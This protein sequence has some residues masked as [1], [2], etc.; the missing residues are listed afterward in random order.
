MTSPNL[1]NADLRRLP[2]THDVLNVF[3]VLAKL[4]SGHDALDPSAPSLTVCRM[5]DGRFVLVEISGGTGCVI[6]DPVTASEAMEIAYGALSGDATARDKLFSV[7][8]AFAGVM[9]SPVD[10]RTIPPLPGDVIALARLPAARGA[11]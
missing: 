7:A 6:G 11:A 10:N 1:P 5:P 9:C 8:I 2:L 3:R 4:P